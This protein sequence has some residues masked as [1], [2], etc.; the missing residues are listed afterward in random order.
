[1]LSKSVSEYLSPNPK[2]IRCVCKYMVRHHRLLVSKRMQVWQ[3]FCLCCE[4]SDITVT[5]HEKNVGIILGEYS[6]NLKG[7][8]EKIV[9]PL[10]Q[11]PL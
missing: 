6:R 3:I 11:M 9:T 2:S 1:M 5:V 8:K 7:K 10:S 4:T